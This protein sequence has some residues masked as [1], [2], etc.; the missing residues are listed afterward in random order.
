[1][2]FRANT[3]WDTNWGATTY[4]SGYGTQGG[5][6]IPI[7]T[8]GT[9]FVYFNSASGEYFIGPT[10]NSV[11]YGRVG[12]IGTARPG[13]WGDPDTELTKNPS[14]PYKYSKILTLD[15]GELKFRADNGWGVNWGASTFPSG[16]GVQNGANIPI[17]AGTY[18]ISFNSLTGEYRFLK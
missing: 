9:Y 2:K 10:S 3:S 8:A 13:G 4:P 16:I 15:D 5:P 12:I 14:N 17:S 11:P 18:F 7:P 6:N 1:V